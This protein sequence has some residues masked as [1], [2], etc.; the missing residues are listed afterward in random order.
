MSPLN[1]KKLDK[2]RDERTN[3]IKKAALKIFARY[4]Y[5]GTK[6]SLVA[7]EAGIS[8]GLIYKYFKSKDELFT[9]LIQELMEE[10]KSE[11]EGLY[12]LEGSP[13]DQIRTLTK[14]MI[15]EE[16]RDAFVLIQRAR[17]DE[18]VPE[19]IIPIFKQYSAYN[20]IDILVPIIVK[21]Q[22]LGEFSNE[23]PRKLASWYFFI[24]N[25]ICIQEVE[26]EEYGLPSI[27]VLMRILKK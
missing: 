18:D 16:N 10:A 1:R 21:G 4:G 24:I 2:I 7:S 25:S 8:E 20:L 23:D 22:E 5:L 9:T 12:H 19:K 27:D 15:S 3:Q 17:K 14:N 26:K 13:F 11:L 6:T